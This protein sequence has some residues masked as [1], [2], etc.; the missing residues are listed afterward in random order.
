MLVARNVRH[1]ACTY[2]SIYKTYGICRHLQNVNR[3]NIRART[4][5]FT[6][7]RFYIQIHGERMP[8]FQRT[9]TCA[10]MHT[11]VFLCTHAYLN[12]FVSVD[13]YTYASTNQTLNLPLSL[14]IYIYATP[15]PVTYHFGPLHYRNQCC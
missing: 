9:G 6:H 4:R 1:G 12:T 3:F 10:H 5:T 13:V 11:H 2:V 15:P 14:S 7:I 8:A